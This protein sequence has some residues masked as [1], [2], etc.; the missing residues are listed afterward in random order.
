MTLS[1]SVTETTVQFVY[2][3]DQK[4]VTLTFAFEG[5]PNPKFEQR[6]LNYLHRL[7]HGNQWLNG[8]HLDINS[9]NSFPHSSGIASS[10]SAFS[11]L[12]LALCSV[13]E[14]ITGQ[15]KPVQQF[16]REA[17]Q[18]AR[19][20]SGSACRSVFGNY[21]VWGKSEASEVYS[22]LFAVPVATAIHP[23]FEKMQ[24]S[25]LLVNAAEKK[26]GS[27][28][29]HGLMETN[30]YASVRYAQ[31]K[32]HVLELLE[33][34]SDGNLSRFIEI[35][36][37]EAL[38]LHALMMASNPGYLLLES[39]T[40]SVIERVRRFRKEKN[41]P[42]CFTLDAGPNVHLLYPLEHKHLVNQFIK[43]ELLGFC[44]AKKYLDDE[45][46]IGPKQLILQ[47]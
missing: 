43:E 18:W 5:K 21:V 35:V 8:I 24:D 28:A 40:L 26:V 13:A 16:Y 12:A 9:H 22:D 46:G 36:E 44:N 11:A 10:A 1:K 4:E 20:G 2:S 19:L 23:V 37:Q 15:V 30:P 7:S 39:G 41:I 33:V 3:P 38:T 6:L 27:S 17:S 42:V 14:K 25:I 32:G 47:G 31:A 34:L 29:G 45:I